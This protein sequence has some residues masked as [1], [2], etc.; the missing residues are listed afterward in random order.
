MNSPE[1]TWRRRWTGFG[2]VISYSR[3]DTGRQVVDSEIGGM[4]EVE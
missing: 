2:H 4:W 1:R 3:R